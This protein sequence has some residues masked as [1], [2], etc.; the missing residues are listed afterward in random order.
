MAWHALPAEAACTRL[1]VDP[2]RGLDE[3]E[4]AARHREHGPNRLRE[5]PPPP[6]W[7]ALVRQLQSVLVGILAVAAVLAFLLGEP[8]DG[9]VIVAILALNAVLGYLQERRAEAAIRALASLLAPTASVRREGR[10]RTVP[11]VDLVPGDIVRVETGDRV[12]ADLRLLAGAELRTDEAPLTGESTSVAKHVEPV[13]EDADLALQ[14]SC[15]WSGTTVVN[16]HGEGVVIATGMETQFGRIAALT[17]TVQTGGTLLEVRMASLGRLLGLLGLAAAAAVAVLGLLHGESATTI[18]MTGLALAVAVVPEGLPAVV[19]ITLALGV[20]R[21]AA[22]GALPRRLAAIETLGSATAI[23]TDKTGT[24]TAGEMTVRTIW[25]PQATYRVEGVGYEPLGAWQRV[26]AGEGEPRTVT[27]QDAPD[28][29]ALLDAAERSSRASLQHVGDA[30]Q[31]VGEPTEA[32]LVVAARK[33]G[34]VAPSETPLLELPFT[35][36]RRRAAALHAEGPHRRLSLK[37]APEV[38]LERVHDVAHVEGPRP[39]TQGELTSAREAY[40]AFAAQ[41]LRTLAVATR[42]VPVEVAAD[43][44][45][46]ERDLT[47]LGL[48]AIQDPPRVGAAQA[49]R[50][51]GEAGIQVLM[52][53][54][55]AP[56]TALAIAHEVGLPAQ[57]AL[58]GRDIEGLDDAALDARLVGPVVLAR[59]TPE[60]KLRVVRR[61]EARGDV[62]A[63]TGDGV[64]DAPALKEADVGVA[65]GRRG[66]DVAREASDL[67]L[68]DDDFSTLVGA[69]EEGRRELENIRKFV[70]YLLGSNVGEVVALLL[71]LLVGGPLLLLPAQI[72]WV[73]VVTDALTAI[74]LGLEPAER[75]LMRRPPHAR[76]RPLL[77]RFDIVRVLLGGC[78]IGLGT[79]WLFDRH[80]GSLAEARTI[81]FT[82]LVVLEQVNLLAWRTLRVPV[83]QVGWWSNPWLLVALL[84]ALALQVV[85]VYAPPLQQVLGTVPIPAS[86]WL[87]ACGLALPLFLGPE[88][89]KIR[90]M[91][92]PREP[93]PTTGA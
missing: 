71:G 24:L 21:M 31:A 42:L 93:R 73:N 20:R 58:L 52:A 46:L 57:D 2:L 33:L 34:L 27:S 85:A 89:L 8:L 18:L 5:A 53:T 79:W 17:S 62:V 7:A 1:R 56:E 14:A 26:A 55:D 30:W 68:A 83:S 23:V 74:A 49:V 54:G 19:T 90:G 61:L 13:A 91:R 66:T 60:Q 45:A 38:V 86:A 16:G 69:V 15:L 72:L 36:L 59:A 40:R 77:D 50:E 12:P 51:A 81:A 9:A 44:D 10:V 88:L 6:W 67:V 4:A 63:M 64:N 78:W 43:P 47:L 87:W 75:D 39:A 84:G 28:L 35:S 65:M 37:G 92:R 25:T 41:G 32:A 22:R 48:V 80:D 29:V 11:A 76:N 3:A 82:A 70:G